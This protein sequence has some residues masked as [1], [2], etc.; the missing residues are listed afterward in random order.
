MP[1]VK[2]YSLNPQEKYKLF[3]E[4]FE[5]IANLKGKKEVI[6]FTIGLL[7]PSEMLMIA[8]RIQIARMLLEE[9]NYEVIRRK[10]KVSYQTIGK[11]DKWLR[12]DEDKN[13]LIIEKI[14]KVKKASKVFKYRENMLDRYAHHRLLKD[15][16]S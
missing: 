7:T 1:K 14:R 6:D 11:V 16:L 15:L 3:G 9:A 5:I 13:K 12:G 8:R 2:V 10:L 4:L